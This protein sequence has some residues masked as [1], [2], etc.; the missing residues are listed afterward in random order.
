MKIGDAKDVA[1]LAALGVGGYLVYTFYN[2]VAKGAGDAYDAAVNAT[3]DKLTD[4][5][6]P[7]LEWNALDYVVNFSNG[8][9]AIPSTS[10]DSTGHFTYNGTQF[11]MKDKVKPD[12]TREHWAFAA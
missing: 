6:G 1:I 5:F 4:W 11:V 10:V 12:G 2:K 9:H 3:A 7:K 8:R